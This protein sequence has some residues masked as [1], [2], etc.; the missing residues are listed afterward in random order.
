M[1]PA[2]THTV[3]MLLVENEKCP[4]NGTK[5]WTFLPASRLIGDDAVESRLSPMHEYADGR[6]W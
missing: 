1:H 3:H 5:L 2:R 4:F 6:G